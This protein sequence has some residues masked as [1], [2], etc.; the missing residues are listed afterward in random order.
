MKSIKSIFAIVAAVVICLAAGAINQ[1]AAQKKAAPRVKEN[2]WAAQQTGSTPE[3]TTAFAAARDLIDDAQ[4]SKAEQAFGQYVTRFPK[5]QNLD[6]AMYWTAYAQYQMKKYTVCK[7][8]IEK[9]LQA[10]AKT[11]WKQDADLLMAQLPGAAPVATAG[12]PITA[13]V[14]VLSSAPIAAAVE[15]ATSAS[16]NPT[17][18]AQSPGQAVT[19]SPEMQERVAEAKMRADERLRDAQERTAER[20]KEM[21]EKMKDKTMFHI[22]EGMGIGIGKGMG[23]AI[24][25]ERLADDDPCEF[26]IVVLQAL[27]ESDP[28][29][30]IVNAT[31]WLKPNSA[32][33]PPC[34]RAALT[35]LSRNGGKT[36]IPTIMGSAQNDPDLKVRSR[37]ISLLGATNDES[38]IDALRDFALNAPQPE[39]NEAAMYALS[40]HTGARAAGIL[41]DIAVSTKPLQLRQ[42]AIA[43]IAD[44]AGEPAVDALFKIY[45][46]SQDI[47]IRKSVINGLARR[48]SERAGEKLL[49]IARSGESVELRKGAISA[50][51][52]RGGTN[53]IDALMGLYDNEKDETIKDQILNSLAYSSD[54][55]VI[56][57]LI[58][59]A[60]NPQTPIERKRRIVMLLAN[61]NKNPAV[62]AFFEELLKQ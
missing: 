60:R 12:T 48:R 5:E 52:R 33:P 49:T 59:I 20:V 38:V 28:Q 56:D 22:G 45:D 16:V 44:R 47:Q 24:A 11:S 15:A 13:D 3:A 14:A 23:S 25:G 54:Q 4:W 40:Q 8:T 10:Y 27:F 21:Q 9:M 58:S 26:K 7:Q 51:G 46:S 31:D 2:A 6:A 30:G 18:V 62:V 39:I 43:R 55:K 50:L 34:R 1:A 57:K 29:R 19:I 41:A 53:Y 36:V 61:K 42:S 17:V 32:Q 35:L 37:A